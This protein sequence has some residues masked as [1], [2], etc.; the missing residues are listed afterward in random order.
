M[1]DENEELWNKGDTQDKKIMELSM[2]LNLA[3]VQRVSEVSEKEQIQK[4]IERLKN[5]NNEL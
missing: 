1:L 4:E 5:R 3:E 2:K